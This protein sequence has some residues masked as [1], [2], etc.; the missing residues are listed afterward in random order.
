MEDIIL[1]IPDITYK[2]EAIKFIEEFK[3]FNSGINGTG[4][5]DSHIENY[6]G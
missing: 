4:A 1:V 6:E 3:R 2:E 5:L